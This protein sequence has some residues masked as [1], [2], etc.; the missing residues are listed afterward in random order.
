MRY[1]Q[2]VLVMFFATAALVVV[3]ALLFR[4]SGKAWDECSHKTST[5]AVNEVCAEFR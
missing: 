3:P 4:P 5:K 2:L 1:W